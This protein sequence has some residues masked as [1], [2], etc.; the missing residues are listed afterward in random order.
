M[1]V[2]A[3]S[4]ENDRIPSQ[5]FPEMNPAMDSYRIGTLLEMARA[6]T[7]GLAEEN[8]R[9]RLC[10]QGSMGAGIFTGLPKQLSGVSKLM[11]MMDWESEEGEVNEGM[12]GTFV[13]FGNIGAEFVVNEQRANVND[14][15]SDSIITQHQ[16]DVFILLSQ[17]MVGWTAVSF[18]GCKRNGRAAGD[19]PSF[20]LID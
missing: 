6:M 10:V 4:N 2:M 20:S 16:D 11:Q 3:T 9:V 1:T 19:R 13:N 12:V 17:N 18:P 7:I 8:L 14:N 5:E 15:D